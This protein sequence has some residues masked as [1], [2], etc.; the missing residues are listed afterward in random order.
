MPVEVADDAV[1]TL[2]AD[3]YHA[4]ERKQ[5]PNKITIKLFQNKISFL[6]GQSRLQSGVR[7]QNVTT[8]LILAQC[9]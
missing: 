2:A 7:K 3:D 6:I 9:H 8:K 1:A 5:R 4:T